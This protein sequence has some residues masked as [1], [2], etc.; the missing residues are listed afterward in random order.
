MAP[1]V[2]LEPRPFA[3]TRHSSSAI[4]LL[5]ACRLRHNPPRSLYRPPDAV[6]ARFPASAKRLAG[7]L[8]RTQFKKARKKTT[9]LGG[10]FAW[11][12]IGDSNP[13]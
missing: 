10:L 4:N 11:W 2:G 8:V 5:D 13:G 12:F 7:S 3:V 9:L 1:Q 6:A